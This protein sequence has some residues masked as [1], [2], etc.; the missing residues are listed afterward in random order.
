MESKWKCWLLCINFSLFSLS[1]RAGCLQHIS[2]ISHSTF[3]SPWKTHFLRFCNTPPSIFDRCSNNWWLC[4]FR[5][6][7]RNWELLLNDQ[8][9]LKILF[10]LTASICTSRRNFD[11]SDNSVFGFCS[12]FG[13]LCPE[14][15]DF[16][17]GKKALNLLLFLF[18][19][20]ATHSLPPCQHVSC[21]TYEFRM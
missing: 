13:G 10:E 17:L 21:S 20:R 5:V 3:R 16:C 8:H 4:L 9:S 15:H 1:S 11:F 2:P 18:S 7:W 19:G 6:H 14:N 12:F